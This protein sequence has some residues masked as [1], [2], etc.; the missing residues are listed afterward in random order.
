M[1]RFEHTVNFYNFA[2]L[3]YIFHV[4]IGKIFKIDYWVITFLLSSVAMAKR[5]K[6]SMIA[7]VQLRPTFEPASTYEKEISPSTKTQ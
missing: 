2:K 4:F 5:S 1:G 3:S 6:V 7:V